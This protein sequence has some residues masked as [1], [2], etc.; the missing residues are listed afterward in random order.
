M[1]YED[2]DIWESIDSE[3]GSFDTPFPVGHYLGKIVSP[4]FDAVTTFDETED[5]PARTV[6]T[7]QFGECKGLNGTKDV[8]PRWHHSLQITTHIGK[9]SCWSDP[10]SNSGQLLMGFVFLARLATALGVR[11]SGDKNRE[12][13]AQ[14]ADMLAGDTFVDQ[15]IEFRVYHTDKESGEGV[16]VNTAPKSIKAPS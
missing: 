13:I 10:K 9:Q 12:I 6:L 4:Y 11:E 16:W 15:E 8:S 1:P 2:M 3:E 14:M 5:R 7:V